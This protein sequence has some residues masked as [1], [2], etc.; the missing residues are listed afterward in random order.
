[1]ALPGRRPRGR[2][3]R[4][5]MDVVKENMKLA[6]ETEEDEEGSWRQLIPCV[7]PSRRTVKVEGQ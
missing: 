4:T 5:L 2:T 3:T 7:D 1:M 6:G